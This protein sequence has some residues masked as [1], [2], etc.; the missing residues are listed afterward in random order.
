MDRGHTGR[1]QSMGSQRVGHNWVI[2]TFIVITWSFKIE[3]SSD[4]FLLFVFVIYL[5]VCF[6][7]VVV[8]RLRHITQILLAFLRCCPFAQTDSPHYCKSMVPARHKV[9]SQK[10]NPFF[11]CASNFLWNASP[12][13]HFSQL[14]FISLWWGLVLGHKGITGIRLFR[15]YVWTGQGITFSECLAATKSKF[16]WKQL[17]FCQQGRGRVDVE[18]LPTMVKEPWCYKHGNKC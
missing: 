2:N 3:C 13:R 17:G 10:T 4:C 16:L 6:S 15:I 8:K 12:R 14:T 7:G 1:P 5:L 18:S 9:Q 11:L